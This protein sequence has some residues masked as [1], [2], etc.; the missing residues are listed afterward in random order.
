MSRRTKQGPRPRKWTATVVGKGM[1]E[2]ATPL[3]P[4]DPRG[5]WRL[6]CEVQTTGDVHV[7]AGLRVEPVGAIPP[8]GLSAKFVRRNIS[9]PFDE[10][11]AK[12]DAAHGRRRARWHTSGTGRISPRRRGI[13]KAALVAEE[14]AAIIAGIAKGEP[15]PHHGVIFA[16]ANDERFK[17]LKLTPERVRDLIYQAR[18]VDGY[19]TKTKQGRRGGTLTDKGRAAAKAARAKQQQLATADQGKTPRRGK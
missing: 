1:T 6:V 13:D 15:R 8:F 11:I 10:L 18:V 14:Y 3:D 5:P 12:V 9:I 19:L 16:I 17:S 2:V 7:V 4:D